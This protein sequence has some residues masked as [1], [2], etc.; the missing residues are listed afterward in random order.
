METKFIFSYSKKAMIFRRQLQSFELTFDEALERAKEH[1][2]NVGGVF[3]SIEEVEVS[4][5]IL[6]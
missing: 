1:C 2:K 5:I 6:V 4:N 3:V